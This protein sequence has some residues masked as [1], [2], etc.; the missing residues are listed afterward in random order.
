MIDRLLQ[1]DRAQSAA[2]DAQHN[3]RV[4]LILHGLCVADDVLYNFFLIIRQVAPVHT[5]VLALLNHCLFHI[6]NLAG[7][8]REIFFTQ[9]LL[10][11]E[12]IHHVVKIQTDLHGL[13]EIFLQI[14]F[15]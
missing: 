3:K 1:C 12:G 15:H 8:S 9:S 7:E 4:K 11:N 14:L 5:A 10:P 13:F 2:A 6:G